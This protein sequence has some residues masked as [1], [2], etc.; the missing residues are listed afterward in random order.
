[1]QKKNLIV[2]LIIALI[3]IVSGIVLYFCNRAHEE[4]NMPDI[5]TIQQESV[6]E[7]V[8]I[9]EIKIEN[10]KVEKQVKKAVES[11]IQKHAETVSVPQA[12]EPREEVNKDVITEAPVPAKTEPAK[13]VIVDKEYKMKS[14]DKYTFK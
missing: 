10:N 7:E 2:L 4:D 5:E 8:K 14:P 13:V 11:K 12:E 1:M 3:L 9:E 6:K